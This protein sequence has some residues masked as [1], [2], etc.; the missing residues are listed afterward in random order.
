MDV[1][2]QTYV[3]DIDFFRALVLIVGRRRTQMVP[4]A[5]IAP[6]HRHFAAPAAQFNHVGLDGQRGALA[7]RYRPIDRERRACR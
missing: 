3:A 5:L 4:T 1:A 2:W 7:D 6:R